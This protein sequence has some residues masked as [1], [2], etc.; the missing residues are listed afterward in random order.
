MAVVQELLPQLGHLYIARVMKQILLYILPVI[1]L[2]GFAQTEDAKWNVGIHGGFSQYTGDLGQG[3]Y[4]T[5]QA[6]YSFVGFS[7]SR[8][9]S[10]HFD[11]GAIA[12][13][14]EMGYM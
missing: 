4:R 9:L 13:R 14:G 6:A 10:R 11:V 2:A 5:D 1:T 8:Y 3:W 7:V 12:T